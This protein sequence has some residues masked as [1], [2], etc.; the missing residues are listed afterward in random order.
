MPALLTWQ[1]LLLLFCAF[2]NGVAKTGVPGLGIVVVPLM[3]M[4][5][6]QSSNLAMG[7]LL[8]LLCAADCC[9]VATYRRTARWGEIA[10][11]SPWVA[12]GAGGGCAAM[13]MIADGPLTKVI[14][15]IVLAMIALHVWRRWRG[16]D[17]V[18]ARPLLAGVLGVVA[19]FATTV[20]N[21]AG[22]AINL[23]LL[24]MAL[25]KSEF[26]GTGAWFFFVINLVKVPLFV[27]L[28]GRITGATLLLD[29]I[30]VPAVIVGALCGRSLFARIPQRLFEVVVLVVATVA[31][32][33]MMASHW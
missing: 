25:P 7:A 8:P 9:A 19:G 1:W 33:A 30:A 3:L 26:M 32:V 27:Y 28:G 12:I 23:Y 17:E 14:G 21:A 11:L 5:V 18:R 16:T 22:P 24:S 20:A 6:P 2:L 4:V 15:A 13:L 10:R 31:T 29:A